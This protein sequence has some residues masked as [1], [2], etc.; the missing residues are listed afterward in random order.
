M[1]FVVYFECIE[2]WDIVQ[3]FCWIILFGFDIIVVVVGTINN[4]D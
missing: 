4:T 2:I 3:R 1:N